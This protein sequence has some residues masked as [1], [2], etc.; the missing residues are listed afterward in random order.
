MHNKTRVCHICTLRE[1]GLL[2]V[3]VQYVYDSKDHPSFHKSFTYNCNDLR[4]LSS[5]MNQKIARG[6]I[7]F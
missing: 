1:I 6:C 3:R 4:T 7:R 5:L 2:S